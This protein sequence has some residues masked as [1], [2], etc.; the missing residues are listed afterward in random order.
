MVH[1]QDSAFPEGTDSFRSIFVLFPPTSKENFIQCESET[2]SD[3][4][5]SLCLLFLLPFAHNEQLILSL[6]VRAVSELQAKQEGER[7]LGH[8]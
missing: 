6:D 3:S 2:F 1:V 5:S 7:R 8:T 4:Q